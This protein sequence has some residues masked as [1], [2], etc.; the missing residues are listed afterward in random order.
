MAEILETVML[1]CFGFSWPM[2]VVK[3]YKAR[4]AKGMSLGFIVMI[5]LGY[6]AGISAK[7]VAHNYSFVLIVYIINLIM[8]SSNLVIY[9]RNVRLDRRREEEAKVQGRKA[10]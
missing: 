6:L 2:S 1:V 7:I 3:N 8:V 9:A 4:S 5:T 10:V